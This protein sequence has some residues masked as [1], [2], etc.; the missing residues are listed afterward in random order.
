MCEEQQ[1]EDEDGTPGS[2]GFAVGPPKA[3]SSSSLCPTA[4][5]PSELGQRGA[6]GLGSP[7]H[8]L[9]PPAA[10]STGAWQVRKCGQ[11]KKKLKRKKIGI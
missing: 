10:A 9:L 7:P 3:A 5:N 6:L 2:V 11:K 8:T 4:P 1:G